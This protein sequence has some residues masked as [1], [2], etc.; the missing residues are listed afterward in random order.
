MTFNPG[1]PVQTQSPGQFPAQMHANLG[2][3]QA[4]IEADH[5]FNNTV[6][7]NDGIH[8]QVKMLNRD[9]PVVLDNG[10]SGIHFA[11]SN[12]MGQSQEWYYNGTSLYLPETALKCMVNFDGTT[13]APTIRTGALNIASVVRRAGTP[14]SGRYTITYAVP[15]VSS[16]NGQ[17]Y[18]VQ[19]S[20]SKVGSTFVTGVINPNVA[21]ATA[22]TDLKVDIDTFDRNGVHIDCNYVGVAIFSWI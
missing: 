19:I 8:K 6:A 16:G 5:V 13:V 4:I 20:C 22:M 21:L 1:I 12:L 17:T 15:F 14:T 2:R 9:I 7:P 3:L 11:V 10:E 18:V